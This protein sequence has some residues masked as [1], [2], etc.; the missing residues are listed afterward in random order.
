[1][2]HNTYTCLYLSLYIYIYIYI[3]TFEPAPVVLPRRSGQQL[4]EPISNM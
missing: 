2:I 4:A 3:Y 1:M